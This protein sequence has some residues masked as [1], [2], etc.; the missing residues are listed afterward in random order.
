MRRPCWT[1]GEVM[2]QGRGSFGRCDYIGSEGESR[3]PWETRLS[4][5]AL[6]ISPSPIH[7]TAGAISVCSIGNC[8]RWTIIVMQIPRGKRDN[9]VDL[10]CAQKDLLASAQMHRRH[11][12]E[13][14]G[15]YMRSVPH[16]ESQRLL[17][18]RQR[19][20][21]RPSRCFAE[22]MGYPRS[23]RGVWK[24]TLG[25]PQQSEWSGAD[26]PASLPAHF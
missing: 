9:P 4:Q 18:L 7:I 19:P 24:M 25:F 16:H 21:M 14:N 15:L 3:Q 10:I 6:P 12:G 8:H 5:A 13:N 11:P 23:I 26:T 2:R 1:L 22:L 20:V 17:Y